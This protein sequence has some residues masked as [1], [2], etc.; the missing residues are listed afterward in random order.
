MP[1]LFC[2]QFQVWPRITRFLGCDAFSTAWRKLATYCL[3]LFQLQ[4]T[5]ELLLVL[6]LAEMLYSEN[7]KIIDADSDLTENQ[8][9]LSKSN[10]KDD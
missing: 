4:W 2:I 1:Y 5:T 7:D 10:T 8:R 6:K 3:C 9:V